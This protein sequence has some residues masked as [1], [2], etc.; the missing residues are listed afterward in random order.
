MGR[1]LPGEDEIHKKIH[2]QVREE[3]F[4]CRCFNCRHCNSQCRRCDRESRALK[5]D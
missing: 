2:E 1:Q 3:P 5:T 4:N